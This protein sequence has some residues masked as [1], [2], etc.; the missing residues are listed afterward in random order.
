VS[1]RPGVVAWAR[2]AADKIILQALGGCEW[3]ISDVAGYTFHTFSA[4]A[5]GEFST[6][7][8]LDGIPLGLYFV[9]LENA[10]R[11]VTLSIPKLL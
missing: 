8:L 4:E 9:R 2:L 1:L 5:S 6:T 10:G 7:R 11:V 3:H